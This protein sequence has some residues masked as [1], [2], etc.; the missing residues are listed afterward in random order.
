MPI[1]QSISGTD[2]TVRPESKSASE[3][4]VLIVDDSDEMRAYLRGCLN[5]GGINNII[6]A[7]DGLEALHVVLDKEVA[8]VISDIVMPGL[9]GYE[10]CRRVKENA[11]LGDIRVLLISGETTGTQPGCMNDEFLNKPF[12]AAIL[13]SS[14]RRLLNTD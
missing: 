13:R 8:L 5:R 1:P 11:E 12:N 9:D 3:P 7:A 10:L 14:V 2:Q 4:V 6:E